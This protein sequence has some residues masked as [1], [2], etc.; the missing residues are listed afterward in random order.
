[1]DGWTCISSQWREIK[2]GVTW[3]HFLDLVKTAALEWKRKTFPSRS[4]RVREDLNRDRVKRGAFIDH[5]YC[6]TVICSN[7]IY[8]PATS[9]SSF[10]LKASCETRATESDNFELACQCFFLSV[11][12]THI[13]IKANWLKLWKI[14]LLSLLSYK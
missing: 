7:N 13:D 10:T 3:S 11:R 12:Q 9:C 6:S 1:M 4:Q 2:V 14:S 8:E 5:I